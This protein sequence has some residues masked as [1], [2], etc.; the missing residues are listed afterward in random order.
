MQLSALNVKNFNKFDFIDKPNAENIK[1]S[2][3]VLERL[4]AIKKLNENEFEVIVLA[5][6]GSF[7]QPLDSLLLIDRFS[8]S[9]QL[10]KLGKQMTT[11]PLDPKLSK[12]LIESS[13]LGCT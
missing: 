9:A 5:T 10:T 6:A 8:F 3:A 13:N 1:K 4:N 11:F 2:T 12:I 7:D